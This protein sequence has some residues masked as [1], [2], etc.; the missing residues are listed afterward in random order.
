MGYT[1]TKGKTMAK[2]TLVPLD[3]KTF[4]GNFV[5]RPDYM[6]DNYGVE[7]PSLWG[8]YYYHHNGNNGAT[9][10]TKSNRAYIEKALRK[11]MTGKYPTV[12]EI[13]DYH[14]AVGLMDGIVVKVYRNDGVTYTKAFLTFRDLVERTEQYPALDED[15][16][17]QRQQ[18][19]FE[20]ILFSE[21]E[22]QLNVKHGRAYDDKD[23]SSFCRQYINEF[24]PDTWE[25]SFE[26]A[27]LEKYT[28]RLTT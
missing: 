21:M 15:D 1:K 22:F 8:G 12:I 17:M 16:Y 13:C 4:A 24:H 18:E 5:N 14:F 3:A 26:Y 19:L 27:E 10:L 7:N 23:I 25:G 20:D 2:Q 6:G 9:C 11:Y 28:A